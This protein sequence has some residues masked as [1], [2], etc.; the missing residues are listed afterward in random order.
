MINQKKSILSILLILIF[1]MNFVS[2]CI[3]TETNEKKKI[4]VPI[5][6]NLIQPTDLVYQGAFRLPAI[7]DQGS[8]KKSWSW[9]GTAMTLYPKG[10]P[11]GPSDGYPGS[12]FGTGHEQYQFISEVNIPIPVISNSK[13]LSELNTAET[14]QEFTDIRVGLFGEL[15]LPCV[16]I[17]YLPKQGE[18]TKDKLYYTW[19]QHM[20]ELDRGP[21]HG[22]F[23]LDLSN[24]NRA[25]P[26]SIQGQIKYNTTD[27][28]FEIPSNWAVENTPGFRLGT[29]RFRDGGQGAQGPALIVYGPWN[30]GNPPAS[31]TE[32]SNRPLILY[33]SVYDDPE[34]VHAMKDYHHSDE[35][36]GGAWLTKDDKAAV[37]FVG[38]K[39]QGKCWYGFYDGTVWPEEPPY[40]PEGP[41]QRGWWSD[42]FTA[43]IIFYNPSDLAKVARGELEPYEPQPY[44][45]LNIDDYLFNRPTNEIQPFGAVSFDREHGIL[46]AFEFRG[47]SEIDNPLVHVWKIK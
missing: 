39:G 46:Y 24:P 38:I 36:S 28:L 37:I 42:S 35:W 41:G 25:G 26:W 30:Q 43:Q 22:W 3:Q 4:E 47:D 32:L 14:L 17:E 6:K 1:F 11:G 34:G 40:P 15:E 13:D 19:G 5:P 18:Q 27:Y 23:D 10:D 16:G 12:I 21:S 31:G 44:A 8:E 7:T 9:G 45:T 20:Q 2:G 29:G 33:S